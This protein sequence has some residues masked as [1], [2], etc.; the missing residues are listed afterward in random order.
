R[1]YA[2]G[3]ICYSYSFANP[4]GGFHDQYV[5]V[6][7]IRV[8]WPTDRLTLR[9]AGAIPTTGLTALQGIDDVLHVRRGEAVVIHGAAGGV[10]S[11]AVQFAK[12]R[13]ATVMATAPGRDGVAFVRR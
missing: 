13:G 4:K 12:R 3:D 7:A 10:G 8:G 6:A 5:A 11:L 9:Q 2:V 1:R